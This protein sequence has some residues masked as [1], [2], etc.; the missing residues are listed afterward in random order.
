MLEQPTCH[1]AILPPLT[2]LEKVSVRWPAGR[3]EV[4]ALV[5]SQLLRARSDGLARWRATLEQRRQPSKGTVRIVNPP[6]LI[7]P[8]AA[9][10]GLLLPLAVLDRRMQV[11]GGTGIIPFELAGP[12]RSTEIVRVWGAEGRR[13]ARASLLLDFPF[14]VA[15]RPLNVRLTG[16]AR[17]VL[18]S[19][20]AG[21]LKAIGPWSPPFR[22]R[23]APATRSRT[24]RC[25]VLLL[26]A[27]A[28]GWRILLRLR[29][30][31]SS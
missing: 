29:R 30:E 14:L 25:S 10:V 18:T 31:R 28:R 22:P 26:A 20:G 11:T 12:E 9:T 17:C 6:S 3:A 5:P 7:G 23:L 15:Y 24:L 2:R 19:Q 8:A 13:G 16:R 27:A 21:T 4:S 1:T